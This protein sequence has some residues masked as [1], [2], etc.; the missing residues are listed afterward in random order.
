ML[1]SAVCF[2]VLILSLF[3]QAYLQLFIIGGG[4]I[5]LALICFI[6]YQAVIRKK[7][8]AEVVQGVEAIKTDIPTAKDKIK[9]TLKKKQNKTTEKIVKKE[10]QKL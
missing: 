3:I 2:V 1:G 9:E 4:I 5:L 10:K 7:A 8:F 6:I